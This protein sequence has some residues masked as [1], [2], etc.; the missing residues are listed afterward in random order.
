MLAKFIQ[1]YTIKLKNLIL[2]IK[3]LC[4][5]NPLLM[6]LAR[7][8]GTD[9]LFLLYIYAVIGFDIDYLLQS[10]LSCLNDLLRTIYAF[11]CS[12]RRIRPFTSTSFQTN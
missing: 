3:I 2:L 4:L 8:I 5:T 6:Q 12:Y 1:N 11:S 9:F 10:C 7:S